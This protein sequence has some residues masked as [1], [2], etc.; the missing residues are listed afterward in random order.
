VSDVVEIKERFQRIE[1]SQIADP[2]V[3]EAAVDPLQLLAYLL[4]R[5]VAALLGVEAALQK[6]R[7]CPIR[8]S[9]RAEEE[10]KPQL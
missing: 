1:N 4:G 7:R 8:E 5:E 2:R 3:V 10:G 6:P 9:S